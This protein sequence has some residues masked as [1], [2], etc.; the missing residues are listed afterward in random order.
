MVG[1]LRVADRELMAEAE[2]KRKVSEQSIR[3][4]RQRFDALYPADVECLC[5]MGEFAC[6]GVFGFALCDFGV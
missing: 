4:W 1:V 6:G 3:C 2:H 5:G